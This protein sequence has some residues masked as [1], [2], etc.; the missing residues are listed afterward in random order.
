MS[1]LGGFANHGQPRR[2]GVLV[3]GRRRC[4]GVLKPSMQPQ[5]TYRPKSPEA[6]PDWSFETLGVEYHAATR[7]LWMVYDRAAPPYYS[8]QTLQDMAD[9]RESLRVLLG[10]DKAQAYPIDYFVM[11]SNKVGVFNLGGD[12]ITFAHAIEAGDEAL[13]RHYAHACIDVVYGLAD[14]LG[15]AFVSLAVIEGQA[16]GGG[17]E[18]A[19]AQDFLLAEETAR[20]GVPEVAFNTFPGMGAMTHL[21][22]RLG[23]ARAEQIMLSGKTFS[24]AEMHDMGVVDVL[25]PEGQAK[26]HAMAWMA[27]GG[28]ERHARRLGLARTRRTLFPVTWDEL[29]RITD[30]WVETSLAVTGADVRHMERL[31]A[32]QKRLLAGG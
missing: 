25:A 22:R 19:L 28:A 15:G 26:A 23:A 9:L 6:F 4:L 29:M 30:L 21:T 18:A 27:E 17:L 31:A 32:A 14:A 2:R 1:A 13:L 12:L 20:I 7:S 3:A 24:G 8:L 11:A 10:S 16:L 5:L